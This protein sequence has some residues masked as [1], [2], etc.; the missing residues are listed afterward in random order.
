MAAPLSPLDAF[1][2]FLIELHAAASAET[3]PRFRQAL[4]VEDK[5]PGSGFDPV[6]AADKG[7]EEAIRRLIARRFPDHGVVGEEH[8]EDRP[9]AEWVWVLDPVDGTRGFISGVPLWTTLIGLRHQ[10]KPALGSI[11][12]PYLGELFVGRSA[13]HGGGARLLSRGGERPLR[14]RPCPRLTDA[15]LGATDPDGCFSP[16]ELGAFRQVRAAAQLTRLGGDAYY[17]AMV[18]AGLM[19][20]VVEAGL[21]PWDIDPVLPVI[22][23]AGGV[24]TDW[25]GGEQG[26]RPQAIA[27]GDPACL[28]EALTALRRSAV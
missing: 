3:L 22:E 24:V 23:G 14:V 6:T 17:F 27:A 10:G 26:G 5:T 1:E 2:P 4:E 16:A 19:D 11:G 20:L 8:G 18:A 13:A 21:K 12:Q 28:D 25:R 15:T 7:A 9:D